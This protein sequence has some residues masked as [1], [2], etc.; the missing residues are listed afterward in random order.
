MQMFSFRWS[1]CVLLF[2]ALAVPHRSADAG[3]VVTFD[4]SEDVV[5]IPSSGINQVVVNV[6]LAAD[7]GAQEVQGYEMPVEIL[8]GSDNAFPQGWQL[9]AV[10]QETVFSN[11]FFQVESPS[12]EGAFRVGDLSTGAA[13]TF[14]TTPRSIFSFVIEVDPTALPGTA[15]I[16]V[17]DGLLFDIT[18][19]PR[20]QVNF[21]NMATITATAIPEPSSILAL[22]CGGLMMGLRRRRSRERIPS[23]G[24]TGSSV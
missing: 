22:F 17:F 10:T 4:P 20:D 6:R 19:V 13:I 2:V 21:S 1:G 3:I 16:G 9:G 23:A 8:A 24:Q 7:S 12:A 15:T 14:D 11:A 5:N 18:G